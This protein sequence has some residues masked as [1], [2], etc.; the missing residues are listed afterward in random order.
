[1]KYLGIVLLAIVLIL[2]GVY[3]FGEKKAET[4]KEVVNDTATNKTGTDTDTA[5]TNTA[6]NT[7]VKIETNTQVGGYNA[8][9]PKKEE[10]AAGTVKSFTVTGA[11]Y[12]FTP[13]LITVKKGD[14]VKL[15]F[16]NSNG[17][18]NLI[19]DELNIATKMIPAGESQ[20]LTF[21][22][23]QTGS[24]EYYCSVGNHRALG[25]K[26]MLKVE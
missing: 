10:G 18:H 22:A 23:D 13:S 1:M 14:T 6:G 21:V 20:T 12:S 7:G 25:M 4:P 26:G 15:T 19:I 5:D 11:N 9:V 17:Y 24:F 2:G 3:I 8:P 16:K